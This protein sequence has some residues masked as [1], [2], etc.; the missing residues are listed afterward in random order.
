MKKIFYLSV[1]LAFY[2]N[3]AAAQSMAI[4]TDGSTANASALLDVKST[5]KG[6]LIPRMN[7]TQRSG[8]AAPA[9]G[10]LVYQDAPDSTGFYYYD[11][12]LWKWLAAINNTD[13]AYWKTSGNMATN[14]ANNF[15]GTKDNQ[16]LRFRINNINAGKLDTLTQNTSFGFRSLES[17][18]SAE[19]QFTIIW[20]I[21]PGVA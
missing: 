4:N 13:T 3:Y 9:A 11:G 6:M 8:I 1:F 21:G 20:C 14:P 18:V 7:K 15:I 5:A 16:P 10:L 19:F 2:T 12:L 17:V